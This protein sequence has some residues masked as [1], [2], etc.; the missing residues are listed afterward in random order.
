MAGTS[1]VLCTDCSQI[2][3]E[4]FRCEL[5]LSVIYT[6][7]WSWPI[8][9]SLSWML[10]SW[11]SPLVELN[12]YLGSKIRKQER[13]ERS[14]KNRLKRNQLLWKD[15]LA[16]ESLSQAGLSNSEALCLFL[17]P[18]PWCRTPSISASRAPHIDTPPWACQ[19]QFISLFMCWDTQP[20]L[21]GRCE[22]T[23]LRQFL[24][25]TASP[26]RTTV[27]PSSLSPLLPP[28][29]LVLRTPCGDHS[30]RSES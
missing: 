1:T 3:N 17:L 18:R 29:A 9:P 24:F 12:D 14:L 6:L 22:Q 25:S 20:L 5:F 26:P 15:S 8:I 21:R 7:V 16:P 23:D 10:A 30:S 19:R 2:V 4:E 28:Q 13:G 11:V 27:T